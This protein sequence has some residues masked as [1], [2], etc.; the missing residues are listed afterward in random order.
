MI[1][2][3]FFEK[4]GKLNEKNKYYELSKVKRIRI[5][6]FRYNCAS[7]LI[8]KN[9]V[10]ILLAKYLVH[11]DVSMTLNRYSHMYKSKLDEIIKLI[12]N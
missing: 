12:E 7:L 11:S 2:F 4:I 1:S 9:I 10:P 6:D 5:H 3:L 8:S